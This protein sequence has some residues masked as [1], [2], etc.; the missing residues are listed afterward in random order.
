[1]IDDEFARAGLTT[2]LDI[3]RRYGGSLHQ[4]GSSAASP[5]FLSTYDN[6][7]ITSTDFQGGAFKKNLNISQTSIESI[8][9]LKR[10]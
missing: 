6:H 5:D 7:P 1:M 8:N 9:Q 3:I 4:E 10:D 2:D